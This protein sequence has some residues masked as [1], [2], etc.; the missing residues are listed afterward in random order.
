MGSYNAV[1]QGMYTT[2]MHMLYMVLYTREVVITLIY[3]CYTLV[4]HTLYTPV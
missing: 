4:I 2:N 3:T 1:I